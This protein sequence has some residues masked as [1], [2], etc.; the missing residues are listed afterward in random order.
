MNW[1]LRLRDSCLYLAVVK[2]LRTAG[3]ALLMTVLLSLWHVAPATA[4][5]ARERALLAQ[6]QL[7]LSYFDAL[8]RRAQSEAADNRPS[9]FDYTVLRADLREMRRAIESHLGF[10]RRHPRIVQ[11]ATQVVGDD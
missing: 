1:G 5:E 11:P 7:E 10:G 8:V 2:T 4:D 3:W 9:R 6:L